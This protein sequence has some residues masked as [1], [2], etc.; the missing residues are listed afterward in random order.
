MFIG[1][2][3]K[4]RFKKIQIKNCSPN[5]K[6]MTA[7]ITFIKTTF[8]SIYKFYTSNLAEKQMNQ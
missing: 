6:Y 3:F 1:T 4:T 8:T 2:P 5:H 7:K